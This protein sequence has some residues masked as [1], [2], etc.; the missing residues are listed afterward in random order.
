MDLEEFFA[1]QPLARQ[2]FGAL[3]ARI[4]ALGGVELRVSKSQVSYRR[5]R[6]FALLWLPGRYLRPPAAA[7]V[8][9]LALRRRQPSPRWKEIVEPY[10]GHFTHHLELRSAEEIDGE[11]LAWID[12]AW[13]AAAGRKTKGAI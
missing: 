10:P 13:A 4:T 6:V 12:E 7:L 1:G 5:R 2:I 9:T 11:V 3:H 8:L